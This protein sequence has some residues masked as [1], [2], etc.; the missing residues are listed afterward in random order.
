MP[1]SVITEKMPIVNDSNV[2][3]GVS[4][5]NPSQPNKLYPQYPILTR[6]IYI[7]PRKLRVSVEGDPFDVHPYLLGDNLVSHSQSFIKGLKAMT[8][9]VYVS[10]FKILLMCDGDSIQGPPNCSFPAPGNLKP[11]P[12]PTHRVFVGP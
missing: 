9:K 10:S 6:N 7:G 5:I 3:P 2:T 1:N 8:N 11:L 12:L 4:T